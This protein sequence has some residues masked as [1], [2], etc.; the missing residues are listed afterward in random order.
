MLEINEVDINGIKSIL[1]DRNIEFH[2]GVAY[3][4]PE[5][6]NDGID[7]INEHAPDL[8]KDLKESGI[9]S[10]VVRG[11]NHNYLAL[12]SIDTILPL[13]YGIPFAVFANFITDWIKDNLEENKKVRVKYI[14][15]EG[16]KYK[17]IIIEGTESEV[18]EVLDRLKEH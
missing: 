2:K 4:M 9:E 17:E 7:I 6:S 8:R 1:S 5:S 3:I 10:V 16:D 18:K 13:I 11:E 14:K 12:R 15:E